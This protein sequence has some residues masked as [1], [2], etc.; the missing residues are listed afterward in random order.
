MFHFFKDFH[1]IS[2]VNSDIVKNIFIVGLVLKLSY[3]GTQIFK[4]YS[5]LTYGLKIKDV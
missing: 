4:W 5:N 1:Q 3:L 2:E